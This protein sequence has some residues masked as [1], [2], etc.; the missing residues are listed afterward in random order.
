MKFRRGTEVLENFPDEIRLKIYYRLTIGGFAPVRSNPCKPVDLSTMKFKA[1][2]SNKF[3][4][5]VADGTL[6]NAERHDPEP[7][8]EN[9]CSEWWT[10][11]LRIE[12]S[13]VPLTDD[14]L[15]LID[16][17]DGA[18]FAKLTE[19]LGPLEHAVNRASHLNVNQQSHNPKLVD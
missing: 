9:K 14:L 11:D 19:G 8:C 10:Y 15:L 3:R 7:L 12:T 17:A 4:S 16:S 1:I 2:W 18:H 6:L 13:G 5:L